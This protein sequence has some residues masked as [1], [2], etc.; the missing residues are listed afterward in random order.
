MR[1]AIENLTSRE[2]GLAVG[3]SLF[4]TNVGVV[5]GLLFCIIFVRGEDGK[6]ERMRLICLY[7]FVYFAIVM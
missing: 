6:V 4:C 5:V 2:I 3:S 1:E 7:L